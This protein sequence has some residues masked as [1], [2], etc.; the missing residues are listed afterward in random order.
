MTPE[1]DHRG[2]LLL[3]D[4]LGVAPSAVGQLDEVHA[5]LGLPADLGDHIGDVVGQDAIRVL[6]SAGSTQAAAEAGVDWI[7]HADLATER[8]LY[9]VAE[10]D[11][12]VIYGW[13][14]ILPAF[15]VFIPAAKS[16]GPQARRTESRPR[17]TMPQDFA[18]G[19][20]TSN[21]ANCMPDSMQDSGH[22]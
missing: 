1:L 15:A 5:V 8:E 9:A 11:V 10:A 4:G 16:C 21:H 17:A 3:G 19:I 12:R 18:A 22:F 20:K 7:M 6:G 14:S 13:I 2:D